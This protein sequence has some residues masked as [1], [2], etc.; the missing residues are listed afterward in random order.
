MESKHNKV[1]IPMKTAGWE[2]SK[3][4]WVLRKDENSNGMDDSYFSN[5]CIF[6]SHK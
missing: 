2:W 6:H 4:A 5:D 1:T 3:K